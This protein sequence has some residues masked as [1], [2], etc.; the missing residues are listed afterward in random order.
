MMKLVLFLC[1]LSVAFGTL[2]VR[3]VDVLLL[4][5]AAP[6]VPI[7]EVAQA[8]KEASPWTPAL[9]TALLGGIAAIITALGGVLV[10]VLGLRKQQTVTAAA[11]AADLQQVHILVNSGNTAL[12]ERWSKAMVRIAEITKDP[13]DVE[14]AR[15]SQKEVSAKAEA[16]GSSLAEKTAADLR[17]ARK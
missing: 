16:T 15:I 10:L 1:G 17:A 4:A 9:I 12:L 5:Q 7:S 11:Q 13:R 3:I 8:V 6:S 14:E 2:S